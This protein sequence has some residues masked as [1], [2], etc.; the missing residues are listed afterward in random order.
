MKENITIL[1]LGG[2]GGT[3]KVFAGIFSKKPM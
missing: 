3:G 2:Y 1:V